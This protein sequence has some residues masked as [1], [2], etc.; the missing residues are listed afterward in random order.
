MIGDNGPERCLLSIE[1]SAFML[2][3]SM[4][5]QHT[6][7]DVLFRSMPCRAVVIR[8]ASS[9]I[10][11]CK[12]PNRRCACTRV[13][14]PQTLPRGE[15]G[16]WASILA[17]TM[18]ILYLCCDRDP[19]IVAYQLLTTPLR[20]HWLLATA[21]FILSWPAFLCFMVLATFVSVCK[22]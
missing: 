3:C 22:Y 5:A 8:V 7:Q 12:Q 21:V 17:G 11:L 16:W 14:H 18:A 4:P 15:A 1:V 19:G 10:Q 2:L 6:C 13:Q 9:C 20:A